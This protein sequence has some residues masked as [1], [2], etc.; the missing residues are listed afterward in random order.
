MSTFGDRLRRVR[1]EIGLTQ[2]EVAEQL[3]LHRSTY[4]KYE[5]DQSE[6][7]LAV[8]Y[9]LTVILNVDPI[10]LIKPD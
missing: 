8:L 4:T 7:S 5:R 3:H 9:R 1:K 2:K 6:P 10:I